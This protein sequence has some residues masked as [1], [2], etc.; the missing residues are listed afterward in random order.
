MNNYLPNC[1]LSGLPGVVPLKHLSLS[2]PL[3]LIDFR[4]II[5]DVSE[6][7]F[8]LEYRTTFQVILLLFPA[9]KSELFS[10][11]AKRG[12]ISACLVL[13]SSETFV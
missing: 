8:S 11:T 9:I 3:A 4:S 10:L 12:A 13:M 6:C 7:F 5:H 1:S 2:R